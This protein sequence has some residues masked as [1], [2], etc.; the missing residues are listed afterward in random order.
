MSNDDLDDEIDLDDSS[1][2]EFEDEKK[3]LGA[4]LKDNPML[5]FG[6]IAGAIVVVFGGI[7]L[8]GGSQNNTG[9]SYVGSGSE[10]NAPP[11]TEVNNPQYIE[12]VREVNERNVEDAITTGGSAIPTPVD[13][14]VGVLTA[15]EED[16][17]QEDPLQRWRRLQEERLQRELQQ[18]Q[19]VEPQPMPQDTGR[20]EAV[21][22]MAD[23]MSEQMQAILDSKQN[24]ISHVAVSDPSALEPPFV[25]GENG[26]AGQQ[27]N[28]F[29]DDNAQEEV[30]EEV[31]LPAG[32][33]E[34][35]QL[36]I[37]ANTDVP[38]PLLA[39]MMSGPFMGSRIIG[40]FEKQ[41][42]YLTLNFNTLV[43]NGESLTI[44]AV[45]L[46]PDTSLPGMATEVDH[47]YLQRVV[48]P[49]AAAF[50]EGA[51]QAIAESGRTT[52]TITGETVAQET[53]ET[54]QE[55]EISS[56][57]E[58][59]GAELRDILDDQVND[60]E[61]LIRIEAGTPM[62]ILF[63]QPVVRESRI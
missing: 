54:N 31:L 45:A 22:A 42:E 41:E 53:D 9:Q 57:I 52:V 30:I 47:R 40:K 24:K 10:V 34:Y 1:F 3:S 43:L 29:Q 58:E 49:M 46:D 26:A 18:T 63:T 38:G 55:Q 11:G 17:E 39:Q 23:L 35:A 37:E 6:L 27:N 62:G 56:G 16:I 2:D 33:I 48:L 21:Q 4:M 7:M 28:S 60:I 19:V 15:P 61:V 20:G 25:E 14:P 44:E 59:A 51:A 36:L 13:P 50:V 32:E 8:F 12:A 5:K